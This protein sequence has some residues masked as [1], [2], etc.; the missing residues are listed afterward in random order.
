MWRLCVK[1]FTRWANDEALMTNHER[2]SNAQMTKKPLSISPSFDFV[3]PLSLEHSS[4]VIFVTPL[5]LPVACVS[6]A[7]W[8]SPFSSHRFAPG[9]SATR[10]PDRLPWS[11]WVLSSVFPQSLPTGFHFFFD[12]FHQR[13]AVIVLVFFGVPLRAHAVDQ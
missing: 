8:P 3:I 7:I 1:D 10:K 2:S 13:F 9:S 11:A 12:H 4:F 6:C 5:S